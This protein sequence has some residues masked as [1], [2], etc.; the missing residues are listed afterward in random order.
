[1]LYISC[2]LRLVSFKISNFENIIQGLYLRRKLLDI[3]FYVK[4][5]LIIVFSSAF[6]FP[7][8][9]YLYFFSFFCLRV[10]LFSFKCIS[11]SLFFSL[12][13]L[14]DVSKTSN[15]TNSLYPFNSFR[16]SPY[17]RRWRRWSCWPGPSVGRFSA[18]ENCRYR[19]ACEDVHN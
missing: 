9:L 12:Y 7:F 2:V 5:I 10:L 6:F 16:V 11:S 18:R 19:S 15:N 4:K 13:L 1:M 14:L 8:P 3:V 17:R